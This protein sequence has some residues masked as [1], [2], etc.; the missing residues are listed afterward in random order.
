[1]SG[2]VPHGLS[3]L[4]DGYPGFVPGLVVATIAVILLTA[5]VAR[6]LGIGRPHAALLVGSIGVIVAATLFPDVVAWVTGAPPSSSGAP[7]SCDLER[8]RPSLTELLEGSEATANVLLF[9]PLGIAV[10]LLP[11]RIRPVAVGLAV[12]SPI[13]IEIIQ[14]GIPLLDR[15]CQGEDVADNLLGLLLGVTIGLVVLWW[16]ARRAD[17]ISDRGEV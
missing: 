8:I 17:G 10:A 11:R 9:V 1:M 5:P 4:L 2:L 3:T 16:R 6:A 15:R 7:W 13:A 14:S 12:L